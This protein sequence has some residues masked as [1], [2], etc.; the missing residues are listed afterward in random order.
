MPP[1]IHVSRKV[2]LNI[3]LKVRQQLN[4]MER[5]NIIVKRTEPTKWVNSPSIAKKKNDKVRLCLDLSQ[6]NQ[7]N[8]RKYF[9][10]P[11]FDDVVAG[12]HDNKIFTIIDVRGGFWHI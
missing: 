12:I 5:L 8:R 11:M 6:L 4:D 3:R 10:I 7:A 1:F 9:Q 2:P